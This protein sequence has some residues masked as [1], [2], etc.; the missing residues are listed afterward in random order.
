MSLSFQEAFDFV[1]HNRDHLGVA[2][3]DAYVAQLRV[4]M[5]QERED[6]RAAA[7]VA[8]DAAKTLINI[9]V[10]CFAA[11]GAVALMYRS[12]HATFTLSISVVLLSISALVTIAGI[13]A[14]FAAIGS[15]HRGDQ[16]PADADGPL[17][18][19]HP[20]SPLF[21]VQSL[22]GL[23][24][25]VLLAIAVLFWDAGSGV[26]GDTRTDQLQSRVDALQARLDQ[27]AGDLAKASQAVNATPQLNVVGLTQITPKLDAIV[28]ALQELKTAIPPPTPPPQ[29]IVIPQS[30]APSIPPSPA[31]VAAQPVR[32]E[33]D[34]SR[35]D[36]MKI[37]EA[38]SAQ[39]Y[40]LGKIDGLAKRKTR[41]AIRAYQAKLQAPVDGRLTPQQIE[42][43]LSTH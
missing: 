27:Q 11:L 8:V 40:N 30:P 7:T 1:A 10:A 12:T 4:F 22:S 3:P 41:E 23:G 39:G 2:D 26:P 35:P 20:L 42:D 28:S 38:L 15:A 9:G 17:R 13:I 25:L 33:A 24:A 14:G 31:P 43:L 32:Q 37:Q 16:S 6:A 34:L 36:W 19:T 18:A 5:E 21:R 29:P